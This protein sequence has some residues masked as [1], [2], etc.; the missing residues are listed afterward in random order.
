MT[1]SQDRWEFYRDTRAKWRWRRIAR[2]G[3]I[4]AA[5][6]EG[7]VKRSACVSNAQRCGFEGNESATGSGAIEAGPT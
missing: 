3:R 6:S 2:N 1:Q 7:Y 4:I 5:S